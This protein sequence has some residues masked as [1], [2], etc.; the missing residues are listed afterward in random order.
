MPYPRINRLSAYRGPGQEDQWNPFQTSV[1]A[2]LWHPDVQLVVCET[3]VRAG[4]TGIIAAFNRYMAKKNPGVLGIWIVESFKWYSRIAHTPCNELFGH[5]AV[6]HHTNHT[7]TWPQFR[8]PKTGQ[9]SRVMICTYQDLQSMQGAT[10]GWGTID[11]YQNIGSDAYNELMQRISDKRV[12]KSTVLIAGLPVFSS[13]ADAL[14]KSKNAVPWSVG[15]RGGHSTIHFEAIPTSVN[16][17]NLMLEF[18]NVLEESLDPEEY[19][20]RVKGLRPLPSGTVFGRWSTKTWSPEPW[21]GGNI[22]EESYNPVLR[23]SLDM[24]F[25]FRRFGCVATQLDPIRGLDIMIDD[26]NYDNMDTEDICIELAKVYGRPGDK[27]KRRLDMICCDPAGDSPQTAT[28]LKDIDIVR[29]YFPWVDIRFSYQSALRNIANGIKEMSARVCN[30]AGKRR[31]VMTR[32]CW[33]KGLNDRRTGDG[34]KRIKQGRSAALSLTRTRFP[35]DAAGRQLSEEPVKCPIDGHTLDGMRYGIVNR[36]GC[37]G[38]GGQ[39][40]AR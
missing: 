22:V 35:E 7:W 6:W 5:E 13:W 34:Y 27:T 20:R 10:A 24:D 15:Q 28:G 36:H 25:G 40:H 31:W 32:A 39:F 30:A 29:R 4:K 12:R 23:L 9:C 38:V 21:Q 14:A 3:G 17:S 37:N 2:A 1:L 16:E 26:H 11:E 19:E 8:D 18:T 33:D